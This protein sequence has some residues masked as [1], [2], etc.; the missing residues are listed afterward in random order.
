MI[1]PIRRT[2]W[3]TGILLAGAFG[4]LCVNA[5]PSPLRIALPSLD[6]LSPPTPPSIFH[7]ALGLH[8]RER[9]DEMPEVVRVSDGRTDAIM[10]ALAGSA[11]R[12]D[13]GELPAA[14][15]RLQPVDAFLAFHLSSDDTLSLLIDLPAQRLDTTLDLSG[16]DSFRERIQTVVRQIGRTLALSEDAMAVLMEDRIGGTPEDFETYYAAQAWPA[17]VITPTYRG[18]EYADNRLHS[19]FQRW[20]ANRQNPRFARE[21]FRNALEQS[22]SKT[23]YDFRRVDW[24]WMATE[25]FPAILGSAYEEAAYP[26]IVR[27]PKLFEKQIYELC[28]PFSA[29]IGDPL[30][31]AGLVGLDDIPSQSTTATDPLSRSLD[32]MS[33][34]ARPE[35]PAVTSG[36]RLGA[37]RTLGFLEQPKALTVLKE[38][39]ENFDERIRAATAFALRAVPKGGGLPLL[40]VLARDKDPTVVWTARYGLWQ[41]GEMDA[42]L[43]AQARAL[44]VTDTAQRDEAVRVLA[45]LGM[46]EDLPLLHRLEQVGLPGELRREIMLARLRLD[47]AAEAEWIAWLHDPDEE[48]VRA[49]IAQAAPVL[50]NPAIAAEIRRLTNDPYGLLARAARNLMLPLRPVKQSIEQARYDLAYEEPYLRLRAVAWLAEHDDPAALEALETACENTDPHL[51]TEALMRLVERDRER[52]RPRVLAALNDPHR[53]VAFHAAVLA[54][55]L[56]DAGWTAALAA[57][58][59]VVTEPAERRYLDQALARA[60]GT[61]LPAALP[62]VRSIAGK[63]NLAWNTSPASQSD[64]SP[65]DAYYSMKVKADNYMRKAYAAGKIIFGR[66]TPI[67]SPGLIMVNQ[68]QRDSF[69]LTLEEQLSLDDLAVLDG[70]I[71]GEETMNLTPDNLWADGWRSFCLVAGI[72]AERVDGNIDNLNTVERHAWTTWAGARHIEGFNRLYD[73]TKRKYGI[74]R[75]GIQVGTFLPAEGLWSRAS[76]DA[77]LAWKFDL[78]G[79]YD[80][81]GD[82]RLAG[83]SLIRRYKTLW[84]ER[85]VLWLSLGIGGYEMNPVRHTQRVPEMPMLD[86][87]NRAYND[88]LTAWMAGAD[89]GWFSTWMFVSPTFKRTGMARLRGVQL[90]VEDLGPDTSALDRAIAY[91]FRGVEK[92]ELDKLLPDAPEMPAASAEKL[93]EPVRDLFQELEDEDLEAAQHE[94]ISEEVR[95]RRQ[96][97]K[98][99]F[100]FYQRYIYDC[101]RIF[102]SLP[103]NDYRPRALVI[104]HGVTVWTR[105]ARPYPLIPG[106]ALL[107]EFDFL[108]DVNM[109]PNIDLD[110]YRYLVVHQPEALRDATIE[111]ITRWLRE[112][113]GLL[114]VHLDLTSDNNAKDGTI[115]DHVGPLLNDWPWEND[116]DR[117]LNAAGT[118]P[119]AANRLSNLRLETPGGQINV[120]ELSLQTR[121]NIT[122]ER[123]EALI[124]RGDEV[125]LALWRDPQQFKGAVLFD[126]VR[127][128]S[129]EYLDAL[130]AAVNDLAG[131]GIGLRLEPPATMEVL[132]FDA[133]QA[134]AGSHYYRTVRDAL[135]LEGLE[136][137]TGELNPEV[138]GPRNR[139]SALVL[140]DYANRFVA[141]SPA[142]TVVADEPLVRAEIEGEALV[143][144][145]PGILRAVSVSGNVE[146]RTLSGRALPEPENFVAWL[147]FSEDEGI[148]RFQNRGDDS[149]WTTYVRC[150]EPVRLQPATITPAL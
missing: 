73:F 105:P 42:G 89:T 2:A 122:G 144:H 60:D 90:W 148:A 29:E 4:A 57:R 32:S 117:L 103:R 75:P 46:A 40:R 68:S 98:E 14:F 124:R 27:R 76:P 59:A 79:V 85:P 94:E 130:R 96:R 125:L 91:S 7:C 31:F 25:F 118:P 10:T 135:T 127:D 132:R 30:G 44:A 145:A 62:S 119:P 5:A 12:I 134:A 61:A 104:R 13:R 107:Q 45:A 6:R 113:P 84:P 1:S 80:Y 149:F 143:V 115:D 116:I 23:D 123:A 49:A 129:I 3:T 53:W 63:R 34:I 93:K 51:R 66:A 35:Q 26:L 110:R 52:A 150:R 43:L 87:Y 111:R 48:I 65:F 139:R 83:Y 22:I 77:L 146:V 100:L 92:I 141:A 142:V 39:A 114:V 70:L 131:A 106:E 133:I 120:G 21:V 99:G 16:V 140:R 138:G 18:P 102:A 88:T 101:A 37:L 97:F 121:W 86:R 112:T 147:L 20:E 58:R 67:A 78:G 36:M 33:A 55:E 126:G 24:A 109:L 137:M 50:D 11:M 54:A 47:D 19:L 28:E 136:V 108:C 72:D 9:F 17:P 41:A 71:Y 64:V 82:N 69:W 95:E 15:R 81:K 74:L 128:A 56:A 38:T 8:L